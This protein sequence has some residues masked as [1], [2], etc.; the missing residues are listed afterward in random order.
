M[1]LALFLV[2]VLG[3]AAC[4]LNGAAPGDAQTAFPVLSPV[5]VDLGG[6]EITPLPAPAAAD[7]LT[8]TPGAG[9][10]ATDAAPASPGLA[11]ADPASPA[12]AGAVPV[13]E[14][15]AA[16]PRPEPRADP[17][18]DLAAEEVPPEPPAPP[19]PK[20]QLQ[21]AC[22]AAN[23]VWGQ[24]ENQGGFLCQKRT[25]DGGQ[26]CRKK[27]DCFGECLAPSQTCSPVIPLMGCN[28]VLDSQGRR[29]TL[30]LD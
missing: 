12:T 9:D 11:G 15:G 16:T 8:A 1:R 6:I 22:E 17:T 30:C 14:A 5:V 20:S 25:R 10:A 18:A 13:S 21:L 27:E 28:D 2:V 29:M 19:P 4:T 23:G 7:A 24:S 3:L 26:S